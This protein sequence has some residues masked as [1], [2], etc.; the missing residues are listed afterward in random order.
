MQVDC[1]AQDQPKSNGMLPHLIGRKHKYRPKA[2]TQLLNLQQLIIDSTKSEDLTPNA[3]ASLARSWDVL[4]T[5]RREMM[6]MP[7]PKPVDVPLNRKK[8]KQASGPAE[9]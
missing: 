2:M 5:K 3:L 7:K 4:E 9:Q 1:P 8:I 6:M